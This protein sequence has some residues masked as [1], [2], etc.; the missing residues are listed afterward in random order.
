[1][2]RTLPH[3]W[4]RATLGD[5]VSVSSEKVDPSKTPDALYIGLEHIES[6]KR[7][8]VGKG[9]ARDV[10]STKSVFHHGEI[11]YGKLRPYLNKV[12]LAEFDGVCSTD[13]LVL[14]AMAEIDAA[15]VAWMLGTTSFIEFA[16]ANS[17]GINL[18]RT[19]FATLQDYAFPLPPPEEQRRIMAR[20]KKLESRTRRARAALDAIPPLLDQTRRSLL[21][22][23]FGGDLTRD[24]RK[25]NQPSESAEALILKLSANREQ[26]AAKLVD[27]R[28]V[29]PIAVDGDALPDLPP[30]WR[31][32]T[33][34]EIVE[35]GRPIIYGII[36]PGPHVAGGVPYVRVF[37]MKDGK[38][39]PLAQ[40]N[41]A[42]HDRASKFKRAT[43]R[44]GDLLISKD[45][46]IG[47]VAIVPP[48]LDGGNITQ[49]LVRVSVHPFLDRNY[50]AFAIRSPQAQ[51]W[52]IG[53][54]KGVALQGVNVEDF[55]RLP[56]PIPPLREQH[57]IV[58]RLEHA[59]A[60]LD[61]V[62]VAH[63]GAV[64]DIDRLDQSTLAQAFSGKLV[65]QDPRDEPADK[66]LERIRALSLEP[67][68]RGKGW[69]K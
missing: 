57:E 67:K 35:E 63:A 2:N 55:R 14:R 69:R 49:H 8:L 26:S 68:R 28:R 12:W 62:A 11:L 9:E 29:P 56:L 36:K 33:L 3:G 44:T 53:E 31:W 40:L 42:S 41:R 22:S 15:F 58:R 64:V 24:W 61:K 48:E 25:R 21:A 16:N 10:R 13:I 45:G 34:D 60:R 1:M 17:A 7:R 39:A 23:T 38:V 51:D 30:S 4:T 32:A 52:L 50:I 59:L 46:T 5:I 65:P 43:L 54:K 18:P 20:L 47:R 6:G 19:S 37:E 66:L 27:K